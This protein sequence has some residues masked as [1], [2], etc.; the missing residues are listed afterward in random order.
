VKEL[1][2]ATY[3]LDLVN[4]IS[5]I[6]FLLVV[7][8]WAEFKANGI[9][10]SFLKR[11]YKLNVYHK[12]FFSL[13]FAIFYLS[14]SLGRGGDTY[15]YWVTSGA[16]ERL[17]FHDFNSFW[18]VFTN[19]P[20]LEIMYGNFN[21]ITGYPMRYIYMEQ[22]SFFVSKVFMF[23][24]IITFDNYFA[25]TF[26]TAFISAN[27]FWN[28]YKI[29]HQM[30]LFHK[31][32]LPVFVLFLPSVAF[33]ASGVSKDT[34]VLGSI[35]IL[36]CQL[37]HILLRLDGKLKIRRLFIIAF[38]V[39]I[40]YETRP[41]I[42][43]AMSLPLLLMY[44]TNLIN[45]IKNFAILRYFILLIVYTVVIGGTSFLMLTIS[46]ESLLESS[47][48]LYQAKVIQE[49]FAQN[50]LYGED[51]GKRYDLGEVEYSPFGILKVAP[52]AIIAGIYRPYIWEALSPSLFFN[53][54]ESILL[55]VLTFNLF[56]R[57]LKVRIGVIR[58]NELLVFSIGFIILIAFMAGFTS[59]LFGVLVRI[60][61]PLLPFLGLLLSIDLAQ[62]LS[63]KEVLN[64]NID[65]PE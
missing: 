5:T 23:F 24:R 1:N 35:I 52:A 63:K 60:R 53:G 28:L 37:S 36:I 20:S 8:I 49:D 57:Q 54:L 50:K 2:L 11:M 34:V 25:T 3:F 27:A 47:D 29:A 44:M 61:A 6:F 17:L 56:F 30:S 26:L 4:L 18:E 40:I 7:I 62:V 48:S 9:Q 58:S 12:L 46:S 22:E 55:L 39:Y 64:N 14:P 21:H 19:P 65:E 31:Y 59:V 38:C 33:W 32:L 45:R 13:V 10:D 15:S 42:L 41:F 43:Y 16:L 51:E